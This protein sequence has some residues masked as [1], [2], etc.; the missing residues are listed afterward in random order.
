MAEEKKSFILYAD[1]INTVDELSDQ[2]AGILFK[3]ILQY[4]NDRDPILSDRLLQLVFTPIKLQLKRDLSKWSLERKDRSMSGR[5]GNLKRWNLDLYEKVIA[6]TMD[7]IE[8]EN[9]AKHRRA[10]KPIA[11]VANVAVNVTVNDTVTDNVND[12]NIKEIGLKPI[13]P[14]VEKIESIKTP[15]QKKIFAPP[16]KSEVVDFMCEKLDDFTAQAQADL[17]IN[18]YNSN[19]WKVGKNKMQNWKAAAAGW[20]SRMKNFNNDKQLS[21]A[22]RQAAIRKRLYNEGQAL[23]AAIQREGNNNP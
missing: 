3:H 23:Y 6:E 12:I 18:Y 2:E 11:N 20:I 17:F 22:D 5:L 13:A 19:G 7:I 9:I 21:T 1:F 15:P 4:V 8:A 14:E 16:E 10:T